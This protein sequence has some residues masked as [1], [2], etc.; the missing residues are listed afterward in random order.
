MRYNDSTSLIATHS[1]QRMKYVDF[2]AKNDED[3]RIQ[4][5]DVT[6]VPG[7]LNKKFKIIT[8]YQK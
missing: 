3:R 2:L 5:F 1:F 8:Y 7:N 4:I 6:E